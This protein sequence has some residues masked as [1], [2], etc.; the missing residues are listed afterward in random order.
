MARTVLGVIRR[1]RVLPDGRARAVERIELDTPFGK[2]SDCYYR[3]QMASGSR[4]SLAPRPWPSD[5]AFGIKLSREYLRMKRLG[6]EHLVSVSTGGS[7]KEEVRA[8][9]FSPRR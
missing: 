8:G 1:E 5:Y 7:M 3:G 4:I 9:R 2:P 6:V